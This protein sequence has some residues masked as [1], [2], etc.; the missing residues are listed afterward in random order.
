MLVE[1]WGEGGTIAG[2]GL[3]S[4]GSSPGSQK[5]NSWARSIND[6][7]F[8]I[9][10]ASESESSSSGELSEMDGVNS[11]SSFRVVRC[12]GELG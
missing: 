10:G 2:A 9:S 7:S 11:S 12:S 1:Q 4:S 3:G 5:G 8:R 6:G